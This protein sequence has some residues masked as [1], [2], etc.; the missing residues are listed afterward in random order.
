VR[1]ATRTWGS[2]PRRI[3]LV[4]GL[5][6]TSELWHDF[7]SLVAERHDATVTAVDLRGH[8]GSGRA[9]AGGYRI[10]DFA[11][12][13]DE[14]LEPRA[15]VAIGH[16]LGGRVL[17]EALPA[18]APRRALFLDPGFALESF[19]SPAGRVASRVPLTGALASWVF[20][21]GTPGL[22]AANRARFRRSTRDWDRRMTG[23]VVRE[24]AAHPLPVRPPDVPAT[25]LL[26]QGSRLVRPRLAGALATAGWDVRV[27]EGSV[28]D[29]ATLAPR[30][31]ADAVRDVL[32][33]R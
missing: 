8:G 18:L 20:T 5:N 12:D 32:D 28:H 1:L 25:L 7:A 24:L 23:Q 2:G 10:V 14:T 4:H 16:S 27:L 6:A 11:G 9:R 26:S 13:L 29:M 3:Q 21:W 15:A 31:T 22:T 19:A 17:A 30:A 33:A